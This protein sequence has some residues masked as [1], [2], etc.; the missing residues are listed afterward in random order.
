[1]SLWSCM[2]LDTDLDRTGA[3]VCV[4]PCASRVRCGGR[5]GSGGVRLSGSCLAVVWPWTRTFG[6]IGAADYVGGVSVTVAT[7]VAVRSAAG[8]WRCAVVWKLSGCCLEVVCCWIGENGL[9]G[10]C[11]VFVWKLSGPG[12][13]NLIGLVRRTLSAVCL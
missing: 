9:F 2:A 11:L 1:M 7:A 13:G 6:R 12:H 10:G 8:L 3:A 4:G 5:L